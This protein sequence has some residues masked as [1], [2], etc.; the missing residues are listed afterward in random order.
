[1][2]ARFLGGL[3]IGGLVFS[4]P[5]THS[6]R[7]KNQSL[8]EISI[9]CTLTRAGAALCRDYN[10]R[11]QLGDRATAQ[12][13]VPNPQQISP[14]CSPTSDFATPHLH[15]RI[16]RGDS[17]DSKPI[18]KDGESPKSLAHEQH[19]LLDAWTWIEQTSTD[20]ADSR[21]RSSEWLWLERSK[22]RAGQ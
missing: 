8:Q 4:H 11:G 17:E 21:C 15:H 6:M 13:S 22:R 16:Q 3:G 18:V 19:S 9:T 2:K 5:A 1:M 12:R 14:S 7:H 20:E 10:I